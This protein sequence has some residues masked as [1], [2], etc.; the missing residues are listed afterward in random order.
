MDGDAWLNF[1]TPPSP[2]R[3]VASTTLEDIW[4]VPPTPNADPGEVT[5]AS[6]W[7]TPAPLP[8]SQDDRLAGLWS[9]PEQSADSDLEGLW[10]SPSSPVE[11]VSGGGGLESLFM[12]GDALAQAEMAG[13]PLEAGEVPVTRTASSRGNFDVEFDTDFDTGPIRT[14]G[15]SAPRYRIDR[16]PPARP[17]TGTVS[18]AQ[19]GVVVGQRG[20]DGRF[21]TAAVRQVAPG[22][23]MRGRPA[24]S[25]PQQSRPV[26]PPRPTVTTTKYDVLRKGGLDL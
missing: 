6:L 7:S 12:N 20:T 5:L 21:R 13:L 16:P 22:E 19:D 14:G 10:D 25:P 8:S 1:L 17:F 18:R 2:G 3:N 11:A 15:G 9:S 23:V 24:P 26:D 4:A